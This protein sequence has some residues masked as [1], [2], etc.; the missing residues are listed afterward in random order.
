MRLHSCYHFILLTV[1]GVVVLVNGFVLDKSATISRRRGAHV[2]TSPI[3]LSATEVDN[4][5][6]VQKKGEHYSRPMSPRSLAVQA[7]MDRKRGQF[8][9]QLLESN[10]GYK[11]LD[12]Q[13][14][15]SF[16]RLLVSTVERRMGQIDKILSLYADVY[17]PKKGKN[18]SLVQACLRVGAAQLLFLD[19]ADYAAVKETVDILKK[20]NGPRNKV[21][22]PLIKFV[23]AILRNIGRDGPELLDTSTSESDNVAPWLIKMWHDTWGEENTSKLI[24]QAMREPHIDLSIKLSPYLIEEDQILE[25]ERWRDMMGDDA[26]IL[27]HGSIRVG[28]GMGGSVANWPHYADGNW[29]VQDASSTLPALALRKALIN[30]YGS[31]SLPDLHV[32][33]MCAAPGGKTAQLLSFGLGHVTAVEANARRCRRLD[34]NLERLKLKE[35]CTVV[36]SEGQKWTPDDDSETHGPVSGILVDVPC[37]ATGTG[38]RRPDVLRRDANLGNLL[39]TQ[40]VLA[41]HCADNILAMHGIMVYAT[42]SL[43]ALESEDQVRKLLARGDTQGEAVMKTVP[44]K[45]G[46]IPGFDNAIDEN[47]WLRVLPGVLEGDLSSCDG[48]FVARLQKVG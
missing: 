24:S 33:D 17:P 26:M 43:L 25:L 12:D 27:P 31:A 21:P 44:F 41:T 7:L 46:E 32:V 47:G 45:P 19:I 40:N 10:P 16:A 39:D 13:R 36:V 6:T 42:C 2:R 18:S 34:E 3:P 29:W 48:F 35:H 30:Q 28:S 22:E 20:W 9:V 38:S 23:N 4:D 15:R 1:L 8:A 5:D 11:Q 37:S 14:H